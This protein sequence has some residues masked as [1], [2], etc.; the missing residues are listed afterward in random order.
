VKSRCGACSHPFDRHWSEVI[1]QGRWVRR[2]PGPCDRPDCDCRGY[3]DE[4]LLPGPGERLVF[5]THRLPAAQRAFSM[6]N[7]AQREKDYRRWLDGLPPED[8]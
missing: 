4:V 2:A 6:P 8:G 5:G 7:E 1:E 3:V